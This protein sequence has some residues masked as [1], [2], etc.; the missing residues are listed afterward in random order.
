[1]F[2]KVVLIYPFPFNNVHNKHHSYGLNCILNAYLYHCSVRKYFSLFSIFDSSEAKKN[3]TMLMIIDFS[4][5]LKHCLLTSC[6]SLKTLLKGINIDNG[7]PWEP[8]NQMVKKPVSFEFSEIWIDYKI[9]GWKIFHQSW[10]NSQEITNTGPHMVIDC[11][12]IRI[13]KESWLCKNRLCS[14]SKMRH[15]QFS[16]LL[17]LF[18][19]VGTFLKIKCSKYNQAISFLS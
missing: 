8:I 7:R 14:H 15:S 1:M 6:P 16:L 19:R 10:L 18:I 5:K 17:S 2:L 12:L 13:F 11:V 9:E 3:L 4:S